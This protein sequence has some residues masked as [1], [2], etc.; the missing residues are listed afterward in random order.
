MVPAYDEQ[1]LQA[2]SV[3]L[4][5]SARPIRISENAFVA[6]SVGSYRVNPRATNEFAD[7]ETL[8]VLL[9]VYGIRIAKNMRQADEIVRWDVTNELNPNTKIMESS[10]HMHEAREELTFV[11]TVPLSQLRV[12]DYEI[13]IRVTDALAHRTISRTAAFSIIRAEAESH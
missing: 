8:Q 1:R 3:I 9:Q 2:S 4:T 7:L 10:T 13:H 12:G 5:D 6:P 11:G